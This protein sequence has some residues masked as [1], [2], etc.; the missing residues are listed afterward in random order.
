MLTGG[1][2]CVIMESKKRYGGTVMGA[3]Y[4]TKTAIYL[5]NTIFEWL[6]DKHEK[7][8]IPNSRIIEKALLEY[9][10]DEIEE[11]RKS[12]EEKQQ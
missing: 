6:I 9:Y 5:D 11:C 1:D 10:K 7:T 3:V 4:R 8:D 12:K 2:T